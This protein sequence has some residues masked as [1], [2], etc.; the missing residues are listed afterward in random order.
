[1]YS[2]VIF[3]RA[4]STVDQSATRRRLC[5]LNRDFVCAGCVSLPCASLL[6]P[7]RRFFAGFYFPVEQ[8]IAGGSRAEATC[9][10]YIWTVEG[11]LVTRLEGPQVI[12]FFLFFSCVL[13]GV[14]VE[15]GREGGRETLPHKNVPSSLSLCVGR[16]PFVFIESKR[17]TQHGCHRADS[18]R[19]PRRHERDRV[20]L[21]S[22]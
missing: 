13:D 1:M 14:R 21:P 4:M 19:P 8:Y 10:I 3:W 15:G 2:S 11:H 17:W 9:S 20:Y 7:L 5:F 18:A 6:L 22:L 16:Y 12:F